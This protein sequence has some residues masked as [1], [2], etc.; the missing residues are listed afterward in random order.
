MALSLAVPASRSSSLWLQ[1]P[2][3]AMSKFFTSIQRTWF[4]WVL[5]KS[6]QY[7]LH[8]PPDPGSPQRYNIKLAKWVWV[9]GTLPCIFVQRL[10][11]G[12][13]FPWGI[14]VEIICILYCIIWSSVL[15]LGGEGEQS[16][17]NQWWSSILWRR[18]CDNV[19]S[20]FWSSSL[21]INQSMCQSVR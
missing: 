7:H 20:I 8:H 18:C 15:T 11:R 16:Q 3:T 14:D 1:L 9:L 10:C 12:F 19:W 2:E 21:G 6:F 5:D 13:C 17:A 4:A